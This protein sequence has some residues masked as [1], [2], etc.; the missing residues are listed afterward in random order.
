MQPQSDLVQSHLLRCRSLDHMD[1][2]SMTESRNY[3]LIDV[4]N[5]MTQAPAPVRD[6]TQ[7]AQAFDSS[8][9][10]DCAGLHGGPAVCLHACA[11]Q[12]AQ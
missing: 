4:C 9:C 7:Y 11:G 5:V 12:Q 3:V 10:M 2:Y 6:Y 1:L 8:A